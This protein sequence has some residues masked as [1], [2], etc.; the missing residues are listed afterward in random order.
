[1]KLIHPDRLSL[2]KPF[3]PWLL[4]IVAADE[5]LSAFVLAHM[6]LITSSSDKVTQSFEPPFSVDEHYMQ[7]VSIIYSHNFSPI[8]LLRCTLCYA[9]ELKFIL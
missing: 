6:H 5:L 4:L 2:L 8:Q 3:I 7:L 9:N 1:V